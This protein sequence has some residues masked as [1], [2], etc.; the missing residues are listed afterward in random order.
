MC[1]RFFGKTWGLAPKITLWMYKAI[2]RPVIS[3]AAVVW[4]QRAEVK[5][6][7]R[8]LQ[9]LQR[10]ACLAVLGAMRTTP[11]AAMEVMLDIPPLPLF[12]KAEA[13]AAA[14]RLTANK[15]WRSDGRME[16]RG[17][18]LGEITSRQP[19]L[20]MNEDIFF[21]YLGMP[22]KRFKVIT[23]SRAEWGERAEE[24]IESGAFNLFTDGSH[25][26]GT[27]GAGYYCEEPP[28][29]RSVA[30]AAISLG[31][32]ELVEAN[33]RDKIVQIFSDSKAAVFALSGLNSRSALVNECRE[34]LEGLSH[35]CEVRLY[36]IPGHSGITRNVEADQLANA[37][38][39][40]SFNSL[41]SA[42]IHRTNSKIIE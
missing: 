5:T 38:S 21:V 6:A 30:I 4:W 31:T 18:I 23:P 2:V 36:W 9:R 25:V 39:N 41:G 15:T 22:K 32:Q 1:R 42:R 8:A 28:L 11:T 13:A 24:I 7:A 37:G 19:D 26:N 16:D 40:Q 35:H 33:I 10:T 20:L 12:I 3:Y 29:R 17:K 34:V 27:S 14:I